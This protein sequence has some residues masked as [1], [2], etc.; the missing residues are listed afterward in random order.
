MDENPLGL[1]QDSMRKIGYRTGDM[2]VFAYEA[3]AAAAA[4]IGVIQ[5][6]PAAVFAPFASV[7]GDRYRRERVLLASYLIQALT[8]G[9]MATA[10]FSGAPLPAI[11]VFAA[12]SATSITLT[13]PAQGAIP[14][15]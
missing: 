2:L 8:M 14:P 6:I 4:A 7:L 3:G 12:L 11:Y 9:A 15:P 1:H 5:L 10:L 13:R